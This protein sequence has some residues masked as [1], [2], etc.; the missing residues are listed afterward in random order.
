MYVLGITN[1]CGTD[2]LIYCPSLPVNHG[3]MAKFMMCARGECSPPTPPQQRF[4]DVPPSHP[5]YNFIER[6]GALNIWPP[7]PAIQGV[8]SENNYCPS[9]G[10]KRGE[11]ARILVRAFNL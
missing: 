7:N 9:N 1:G 5:F 4:L 6:M 8:C 10:V 2:P 3:Q 11:M